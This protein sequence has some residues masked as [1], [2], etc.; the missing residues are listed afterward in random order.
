MCGRYIKGSNLNGLE[1][2]VGSTE[3]D[4]KSIMLYGSFTA[5]NK[6]SL[7]KLDNCSLARWIDPEDHIVRVQ[8][9]SVS[10]CHL[11]HGLRM[12]QEG[13]A[14]R[15]AAKASLKAVT[16]GSQLRFDETVRFGRRR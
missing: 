6:D 14:I 9:R 15:R 13:V 11:G 5:A 8:S 4:Y 1:C 12:D 3:F 7:D 16:L 2:K 10:M